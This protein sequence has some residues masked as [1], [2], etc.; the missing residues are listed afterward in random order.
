MVNYVGC[1]VRASRVVRAAV[2]GAVSARGAVPPRARGS[3]RVRARPGRVRVRAGLQP[4]EPVG[5]FARAQ[6][7]HFWRAALSGVPRTPRR[8]DDQRIAGLHAGGVE[9]APAE[10]TRTARPARTE[11]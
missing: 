6:A 1:S 8:A 10:T 9:G 2:R 7:S 11:I 5:L 4:H 3:P